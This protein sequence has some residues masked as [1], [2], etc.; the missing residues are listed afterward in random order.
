[1]NIA[2]TLEIHGAVL[3]T[4][5]GEN[6]GEIHQKHGENPWKTKQKWWIDVDFT[7]KKGGNNWANWDGLSRFE[8]WNWSP[9]SCQNIGTSEIK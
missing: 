1:V 6:Q 5:T 4:K 2:G 7:C 3:P 8:V 9:K